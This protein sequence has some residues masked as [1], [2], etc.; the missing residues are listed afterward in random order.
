MPADRLAL[1]VGVGGE[2]DGLRVARGR[3]EL[4]DAPCRRAGAPRTR[5]RTR[6]DVDGQARPAAGRARG[7]ARRA[8]R[9][10]G[11][12]SGR[13]SSPWPATRRSRGGGHGGASFSR[14]AR[15]QTRRTAPD[16]LELARAA[17]AARA[18]AARRARR[19]RRVSPGRRGCSASRTASG[20]CARRRARGAA[21]PELREHVGARRARAPR[22]RAAAR[23]CPRGAADARVAGHRHHVA[24]FLERDARGDAGR[25]SSRPPR[26]RSWRAPSRRS[27]GCGVGSCCFHGPVPGGNSLTS[28]PARRDRLGERGVLVRVEP[29]RCPSRARRPCGLPASS[30]PWCAAVSM[31]RASPETIVRPAAARSA[32][33]ARAKAWPE[34]GR[35]A[36]A[37]DRHRALALAGRRACRASTAGGGGV[38]DPLA[39]T[40]GSRRRR[41]DDPYPGGG[42]LRPC[43]SMGSPPAGRGPDSSAGALPREVRR[44]WLPSRRRITCSRC[45]KRSC[46]RPRRARAPCVARG[47]WIPSNRFP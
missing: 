2:E 33:R 4:G 13:A 19:S 42:R 23:S 24:A 46:A 35:G 36:R 14:R 10:R 5:R 25:R 39:A 8:R 37:H 44:R 31:P 11:R 3:A 29:R 45:V 38:V 15:P 9:T 17:R 40:R 30:A 1:A 32:A 7:R 6:G 20:A 28:A 21:R 47:R 16:E 18:P 12:G 43:E 34:R 41:A 26:R 22:R 27:C